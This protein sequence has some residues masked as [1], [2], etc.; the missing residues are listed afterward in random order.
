MTNQPT[1]DGV[2][3]E[4]LK[5][6]E[7]TWRQASGFSNTANDAIAKGLG[8]L[9]E[10]LAANPEENGPCPQCGGS[11]RT[12]GCNCDPRWPMVKPVIE[13]SAPVPAAGP[14]IDGSPP[15]PWG[16]EAF[17]AQTV[18]G[19]KV[20]LRPLPEEYSYDF[21]TDDAT[22]MMRASIKKWAQLSTS[23][24][25]DFDG[26]PEAGQSAPVAN[27][28]V[29]LTAAAVVRDSEDGKYLDWLLEGGIAELVPGQVLI[30]AD[31]DVTD[32]C[33]DGELYRLPPDGKA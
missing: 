13:Q 28:P 22:Y 12:W 31:Q 27:E 16:S 2:P 23:Q 20:V 15:S 24:F 18:E 9:R 8:E 19:H 21:T 7:M 29:M 25:I 32:D 14:W 30:V 4:L 6:I 10:L 17:L 1:I 11:L 3:L 5:I 33:G 26:K